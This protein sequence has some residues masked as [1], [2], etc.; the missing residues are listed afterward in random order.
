MFKLLAE[1]K[2][3]LSAELGAVKSEP[4]AARE[5]SHGENLPESEVNTEGSRFKRW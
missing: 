5:P 3:A 4:G 1:E 2:L